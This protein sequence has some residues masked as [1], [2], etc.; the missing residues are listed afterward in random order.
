MVM[1]TITLLNTIYRPNIKSTGSLRHVLRI[2]E[3]TI[4]DS[5]STAGITNLEHTLLNRSQQLPAPYKRLIDGLKQNYLRENEMT[6]VFKP[7]TEVS[8]SHFCL[9]FYFYCKNRSLLS[10]PRGTAV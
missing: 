10:N 9:S 7:I 8:V 6:P 2:L 1:S 5:L 3:T 4:N